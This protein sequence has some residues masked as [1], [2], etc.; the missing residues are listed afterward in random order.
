MTKHRF[1]PET[2]NGCLGFLSVFCILASIGF[3]VLMEL[4]QGARLVP[5]P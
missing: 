2:C 3:P 5:W 1:D 4:L